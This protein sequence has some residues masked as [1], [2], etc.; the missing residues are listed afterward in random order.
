MSNTN[1]AKV[2]TIVNRDP[3]PPPYNPYNPSSTALQLQDF[4]YVF[5]NIKKVG[6]RL[7][8]YCLQKE[9]PASYFTT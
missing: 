6:R 1:N 3:L 8:L 7:L 9:N 4:L 5:F 2:R